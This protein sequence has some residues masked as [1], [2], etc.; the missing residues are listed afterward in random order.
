MLGVRNPTDMEGLH[1][2][3]LPGVRE[4][5]RTRGLIPD[6]P[7]LT[8]TDLLLEILIILEVLLDILVTLHVLH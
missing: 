4:D 3:L 8:A 1:L 5:I 6:I 2:E 7:L